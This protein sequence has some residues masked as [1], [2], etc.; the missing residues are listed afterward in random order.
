[1]PDNLPST[2]QR[3]I[4]TGNLLTRL[5][6]NLPSSLLTLNCS[7]N[8][9]TS[10][11]NLPSTLQYLDCSKNLLRELP[12][13]L[14]LPSLQ[15]L[16]CSKNQLT[17]LPDLPS[18]LE[19]L[20]CSYNRLTILP[21]LPQTLITFQF[22]GNPEFKKY[23]PNFW[24]NCRHF[25][26]LIKTN[27]INYVN[28]TNSRLRTIERTRQINQHDILL[29]LYMKRVMHPNQI[30]IV[31]R[32]NNDDDDADNDADNNADGMELD[33]LIGKYVESV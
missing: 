28:E 13:N 16:Y 21:D 25:L 26:Y 22:C 29:E 15:Y 4:L 2:L 5:P 23:Y 30:S 27:A 8:R 1:L 31:V 20:Y 18:A 9:L 33:A 11:P 12:N 7:K 3:L 6:D 24:N 10:L 19:H 14:N 32:I 17:R